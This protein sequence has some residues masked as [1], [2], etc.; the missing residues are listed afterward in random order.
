MFGLICWRLIGDG[1]KRRR[2]WLPGAP[3]DVARDYTER[4]ASEI[5]GSSHR[6]YHIWGTFHLR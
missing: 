6:V 5:H 4:R 2:R 3:T 1:A